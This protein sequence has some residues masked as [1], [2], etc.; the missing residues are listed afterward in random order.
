M[1]QH[2]AEILKKIA[3]LYSSLTNC[4]SGLWPPWPPKLV[5]NGVPLTWTPH[6]HFLH[7]NGAYLAELGRGQYAEQRL[8]GPEL[9]DENHVSLCVEKSR[10]CKKRKQS[11]N[12]DRSNNSGLAFIFVSKL[13]YN[14]FLFYFSL[15]LS[16]SLH[17]Y[18]IS[19]HHFDRISFNWACTSDIITEFS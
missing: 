11:S 12:S 1:T 16:T 6:R 19:I 3:Q 15:Q 2:S 13:F 8:V 4:R 14:D 17:P 5:P 7:V 18:N 9:A 10:T